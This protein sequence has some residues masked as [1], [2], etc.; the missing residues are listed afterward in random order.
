MKLTIEN[1]GNV[2]NAE[3]EINGISVIA[4]QNGTGKSTISRSLFSIFSAN[5]DVIKKISNDRTKA[6]N[7]FL[8]DY[9]SDIEMNRKNNSEIGIARRI[10]PSFLYTELTKIISKNLLIFLDKNYSEHNNESLKKSIIESINEFNKR[11]SKYFVLNIKDLDLNVLSENIKEILS[12]S[13]QSIFNQILTAHLTDEFHNQI[14]NI[15]DP[16]T[17]LISLRIK[18]EQINVEV[19]KNRAT[20]DKLIN[21]KTD[22][23]Y[24]DDAAAIVENLFSTKFL[25]KFSTKFLNKIDLKL[26]H[27]AHLM[28]QLRDE[29]NNTYTLRAKITDRLNLVFNEINHI[30]KT[31]IVNSSE[32]E[33]DEKKLNIIN[34]SSGMKTFYLIKSLLENGVIRENGTL[35][36][37][38]PEVHLHPEWQLKFAEIIVLLQ[39]EFGLHILINSHSPYLV[40]AIDIFS[41]KNDTNDSVKYYLAN[42]SI[43]DVTDSIDKIYEQM[44]VPLNRLEELAEDFDGE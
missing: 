14:N 40:E 28:E 23:V 26:D 5:Y 29:R 21:F 9:L 11:N 41:K 22:V 37:D 3:I 20:A 30:L 38:E 7:D 42:S 18:D 39:K 33:E 10:V 32:D 6:I 4:G 17:G 31:D 2:K 13:D 35:I 24:I 43:E 44:Y 12:Q 19:N 15:Y 34:Y 36:L 25:N 8:E 1:I 27:N 16:L